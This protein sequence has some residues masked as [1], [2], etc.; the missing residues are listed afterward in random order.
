MTPAMD[1][2]QLGVAG[3]ALAALVLIVRSL[4]RHQEKQQADV[5]M[6]FGNHLGDVVETQAEIRD[7]LAALVGEVKSLRYELRSSGRVDSGVAE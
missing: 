1:W 7:A 6:F 3:G 4:M 2:L 5:L